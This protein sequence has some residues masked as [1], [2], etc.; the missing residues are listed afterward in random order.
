MAI[1]SKKAG[2]ASTRKRPTSSTKGKK[3]SDKLDD[4]ALLDLVPE[5][6]G[7]T[8]VK[9]KLHDKALAVAGLSAPADWQGDMPELPN[10]VAGEDHDTLSNLLSQFT[11]A[12]ASSLW[13]ASKHYV[14]ADAYE[15]I[16]SYL[17]NR[18]LLDSEE[19]NDTKRRADAETDEAYLAALALQKEH[20]HNYVRHRDLANTIDKRIRAVSRI[21]GFVGEEAEGE[22][23][24]GGKPSTRGKALGA[25]KGRSKGSA[26]AR[27]RR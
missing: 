26:K 1:R 9:S 14:E 13:A 15:E 16:A 25:S 27:S 3:K 11:N 12:H 7:A 17:R 18:A 10:D 22:D 5:G 8:F 2:G 19:S 20:Y 24:R 4:D 6:L 21:G 23:L